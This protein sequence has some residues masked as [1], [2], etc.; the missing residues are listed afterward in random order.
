[1][2][3]PPRH[4]LGCALLTDAVDALVAGLVAA[5]RL[6]AHGP[7]FVPGAVPLIP[8]GFAAARVVRHADEQLVSSGQGGFRVHCPADGRI[9]TAAFAPALEDWRRGGPRALRCGCGATHDLR[10]LHYQ[11]ACGYARAWL[12][13]LDVG[14]AEIDAAALP[15]GVTVIWRRG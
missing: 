12:E 9:V 1:M 11:P 5:G 15:P 14:A 3:A 4:Q 7:G 2:P 10:A 6:R 13:L 8:G